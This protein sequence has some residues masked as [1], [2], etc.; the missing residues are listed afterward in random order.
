MAY[1]FVFLFGFLLGALVFS[2]ALTFFK[3]TVEGSL[4]WDVISVDSSLFFRD[5]VLTLVVDT[6]RGIRVFKGKDTVF[7]DL[8]EN[9]RCREY[10]NAILSYHYQEAK[11]DL[12]Y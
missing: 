12:I 8:K 1:I 10:E 11:K 9:Q 6:G 2:F 3:G 5:G 7:F 4:L